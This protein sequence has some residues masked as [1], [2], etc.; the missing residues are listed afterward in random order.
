MAEEAT[1]QPVA[2]V[3]GASSGIGRATGLKLAQSG[4]LVFGVALDDPPSD[5]LAAEAAMIRSM[6]LDVTDRQ[7]VDVLAAT[8]GEQ[9]GG[10]DVL[11]CAAGVNVKRRRFEEVSEDVTPHNHGLCEWTRL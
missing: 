11:V 5:T 10:I 9:H 7:A 1:R 4:F 3:T 6:P 2:L 8:I